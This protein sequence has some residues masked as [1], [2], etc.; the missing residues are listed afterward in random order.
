M[1]DLDRARWWRVS[2]L[3]DTARLPARDRAEAFR[4]TMQAMTGSTRVDLE[5]EEQG[6]A[7]R[8][9]LSP[10]GPVQLFSTWSTGVRM[11]RGSRAARLDFPEYVA[12]AVHELGAGRYDAGPLQRRVFPGEL[13]VVDLTRPYSFAWS[14]IG[15]SSSMM[16]PVADLG[17]APDVVSR[18]STRLASSPLYGTMAH[19]LRDLTRHADALGSSPAAVDAGT[20]SLHLLRALLAGAAAGGRVPDEVADTTLADQ[21][22][23]YVAQ[24]L[25]D[26]DLGADHVA[27]ALAVSRR[28]LFRACREAGFSLEQYV[29]ER[30]LERARAEL[31]RSGRGVAR[32]AHAWGFKDATHFSRRFRTAFGLLPREWQQAVR[33]PG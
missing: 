27:A 9:E 24:H 23:A 8:M 12:V 21:V 33:R 6:A 20:A 4:T 26:P 1:T 16:V 17:L 25:R 22:R 2:V 10:V 29:I 32:V 18:A 28:Q 11:T 7:A 14:G 3:L 15:S 19:H 5:H 30:R 13:M 31:A